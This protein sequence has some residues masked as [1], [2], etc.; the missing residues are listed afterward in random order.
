[1]GRIRGVLVLFAAC[2]FAASCSSG[3]HHA[4]QS[5][6]VPAT[7]AVEEEETAPPPPIG[8]GCLIGRWVTEVHEGIGITFND[9]KV[10][11]SGERGLVITYSAAGTEFQDANNSEPLIGAY[12]GQQLSVLLRG[13][14][15][16]TDHADGR[17][18]VE[19]GPDQPFTQQYSLNGDPQG[20]ADSSS[21]APN[22]SNYTC[23]DTT[24]VLT[25]ADDPQD[26]Q[27]LTRS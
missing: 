15:T 21:N 3:N 12:H 2:G 27:T 1:M 19:S 14:G 22:T 7:E 18:L 6:T 25:A 20:P 8:D 11:V 17:Q 10:P 23:D 9:E 5:T 13:T 26:R 24:L 4:A 16:F